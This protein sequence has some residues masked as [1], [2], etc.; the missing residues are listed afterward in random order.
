MLA[1]KLANAYW[2]LC[3]TLSGRNVCIMLVWKLFPPIVMVAIVQPDL[4]RFFFLVSLDVTVYSWEIVG[5]DC[6]TELNKSSEFHLTTILD[7]CLPSDMA[8]FLSCHKKSPLT[9]Q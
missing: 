9:K 6:I 3:E 5:M 2:Q 4:A 1:I 7:F 8:H